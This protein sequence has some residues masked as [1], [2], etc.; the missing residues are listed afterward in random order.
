MSYYDLYDQEKI[1]KIVLKK[2]VAIGI[3]GQDLVTYAPGQTEESK[4]LKCKPSHTLLNHNVLLVG[5]TQKYWIIKNIWGK[6]WGLNGYAYISRN[7]LEDCCI[8]QE[9][10]TTGDVTTNCSVEGC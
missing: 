8:G 3:C 4:I 1:K 9:L 5:Y 7:Q 10:H 6:N 2:P